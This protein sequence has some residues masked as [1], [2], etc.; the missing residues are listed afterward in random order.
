MGGNVVVF[1]QGTCCCVSGRSGLLVSD[2]FKFN[3]L[4]HIVINAL[5]VITETTTGDSCSP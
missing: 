3:Q 2:E 5:F 1:K 4:L